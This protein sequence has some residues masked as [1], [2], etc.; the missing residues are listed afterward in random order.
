M[1]V[2]L[3]SLLISRWLLLV[4]LLLILLSS[5]QL[6]LILPLMCLF[7]LFLLL[8]GSFQSPLLLCLSLRLLLPRLRSTSLLPLFLSLPLFGSTGGG[9][10]GSGVETALPRRSSVVS[11][12]HPGFSP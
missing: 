5:S 10:V 4:P 9:G 11:A 3:S 2:S 7:F 1:P 12:A 6:F 8:L